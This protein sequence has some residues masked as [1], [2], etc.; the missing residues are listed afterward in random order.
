MYIH[1]YIQNIKH[2][3]F[4]AHPHI[5][6]NIASDSHHTPQQ[7]DSDAAALPPPPPLPKR[8]SILVPAG[9]GHSLHYGPD[10]QL[11]TGSGR[12]ITDR[13]VNL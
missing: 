7:H 3:L 8:N 12:L 5:N 4:H 10:G 2:K 9:P 11:R 6:D 13:T 1:T